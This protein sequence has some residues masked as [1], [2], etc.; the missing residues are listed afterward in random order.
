[1][2]NAMDEA[3]MLSITL[4]F[5]VVSCRLKA[6]LARNEGFGRLIRQ[7]LTTL[8][9]SNILFCFEGYGQINA[10]PS[11]WNPSWLDCKFLLYGRTTSSD[12]SDVRLSVV[13]EDWDH[14]MHFRE[15]PLK[16]FK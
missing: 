3:F 10:F 11:Q 7:R 8:N 6:E 16:C 1:M 9:H 12:S 15:V 14:I 4:F 5:E 13:W 2:R